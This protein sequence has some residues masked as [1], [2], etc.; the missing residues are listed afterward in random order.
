MIWCDLIS[1]CWLRN[2]HYNFPANACLL[3][4]SFH[5]VPRTNCHHFR[6]LVGQYSV[7]E[8]RCFIKKVKTTKTQFFDVFS[9][10]NV[11]KGNIIKSFD[12][13]RPPT[14]IHDQ[15]L[16]YCHQPR[17]LKTNHNFAASTRDHPRQTISLSENLL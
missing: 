6:F 8:I 14:T 12:H 16:F 7:A 4:L 5:T 17:P 2:H 10:K 1:S 11:I 13:S 9:A 3:S 15:S